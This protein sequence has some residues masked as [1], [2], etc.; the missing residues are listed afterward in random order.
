LNPPNAEIDA[1]WLEVAQKRLSELI[2]G[3]VK[4]VPGEEVLHKLEKRFKA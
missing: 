3:T 2:S 4:S 1:Q